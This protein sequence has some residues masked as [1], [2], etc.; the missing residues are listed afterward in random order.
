MESKVAAGSGAAVR[1]R[2]PITRGSITE[3]FARLRAQG[4]VALIPYVTCGFPDEA[5]TLPLLEALADAGADV[6]ELGIPFSDPL[7][8]GP[9]IQRSSFIA[10]GRGMTLKRA[11]ELLREFRARRD[12][13]VVV[14]TYLNPV[15]R[16]GVE[17][18]CR[19]ALAAGAQGLLLTDLP[20]GSDPDLERLVAASG[21]ELVRLVAPTTPPERITSVADAG[22]GFLY[23][24]SRTGVTGARAELPPE[25]A[26]EVK[27]VRARSALPVAVGFGISTPAQAAAV[28]GLADG[29]VVGSALITKVEVEGVEGARRFIAEMRR[30]MDEKV[31]R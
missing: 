16:Y 2:E 13:P 4:R 24:I 25:L 3:R 9:A 19:D 10:L 15:M 20:L 14:F 26:A 23:Y 12:T 29:V 7:A 5:H 28:A 17:A 6:I 30:A 1:A 22:R 27:T 18:F 21:L 11:L 8:D 31:T